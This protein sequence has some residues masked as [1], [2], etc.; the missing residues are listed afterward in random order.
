MLIFLFYIAPLGIIKPNVKL[1]KEKNEKKGLIQFIP[2]GLDLDAI[3]EEHP[4]TFKG[5]HKDN[6]LHI[7][8][9]LY[10]IPAR[11][12]STESSNGFVSI[13]AKLLQKTIHQYK[14]HL[15]YL[16]EVGVVESD[17]QYFV[18]EKSK[19]FR[20]TSAYIRASITS[21]VIHK[22]SLVKA[23]TAL[24]RPAYV[25]VKKYSYLHK[26]LNPSLTIDVEGAIAYIERELVVNLKTMDYYEAHELFR[27]SFIR[28]NDLANLRTW[29][30]IDTSGNRLHTILT[31]M[32]SDLRQFVRYD[33]QRLVSVDIKNSQPYLAIKLLEDRYGP[34]H[35]GLKPSNIEIE[36]E[37]EIQYSGNIQSSSIMVVNTSQSTD[38][39]TYNPPSDVQLFIMLTLNGEFY[40]HMTGLFQDA[41]GDAFFNQDEYKGLSKREVVKG[42]MMKILFSKNGFHSKAKSLFKSAFPNVVAVFEDLKKSQHNLLA[43]TLQKLEAKVVLDKVC[44]RIGREYPSM[45]IYTIHDCVVTTVGNHDYVAK[46]LSEELFFEVGH[47]PRLK[48]EDWR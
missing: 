19:G 42:A 36:T 22:T 16:M 14:A 44:K 23:I 47:P 25:T 4:P 37:G 35:T 29:F 12:W 3:L 1:K 2:I 26:W 31:N 20:L 33:G 5:F 28:I 46:V 40:E 41:F 11:D 18:G 6:L 13:N 10:T 38:S 8:D 24:N 21:T 32:S 43:L 7:L 34:K 45:P 39:L 48:Y 30:T 15:N 17:N 27:F 9:L